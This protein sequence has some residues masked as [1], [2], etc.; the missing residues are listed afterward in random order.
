MPNGRVSEARVACWLGV[1]EDEWAFCESSGPVV[2]QY[3]YVRVSGILIPACEPLARSNAGVE[4]AEFDFTGWR[5]EAFLQLFN[6]SP[7]YSRRTQQSK[8]YG[9]EIKMLIPR[10][11]A[12]VE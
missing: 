3:G 1:R 9:G 11:L 12:R 2:E 6:R 4:N 10:I 5:Q 8:T 7:P